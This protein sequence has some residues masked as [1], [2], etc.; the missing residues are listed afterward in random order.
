LWRFTTT[1][2]APHAS[3]HLILL[4]ATRRQIKMSRW[5][6]FDQPTADAVESRAG[7]RP[8]LR[9]EAVASPKIVELALNSQAS[10]AVIPGEQPGR[11]ILMRVSHQARRPQPAAPKPA[12]N[13]APAGFLGLS[14]GIDMDTEPEQPK[15]WWQKILD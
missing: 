2:I 3:K 11:A 6:V 12:S 9:A 15:K 8:E 1:P 10:L 4:R 13:L 7:L 14:D 5:I